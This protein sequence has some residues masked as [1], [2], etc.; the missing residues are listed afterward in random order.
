MEAL[1]KSARRSYHKSLMSSILTMSKDG[2]PSNADKA[3]RLS[4]D[5]ASG[6][7]RRLGPSTVA[8]KVAG[9]T[10]GSEYETIN[11]EF[12][13]KTFLKM[14]HIRPGKWDIIRLGNTKK[15]GISEY[16]QYAHLYDLDLLVKENATLATV[17]GN[18]YTVTPDVII[19]K[20][21]LDDE[22]INKPQVLVDGSA[23]LRSAIRKNVG[24]KPFLHASISSKWT[25]R[26]DRS[27]NSRTEALN[28]IRNRKGHLP[29][30][31]AVTAEPMPS[32][33]SSIALGTGDIDCVYH[34]MLYELV[35]TVDDLKKE[36][37][38]EMLK[39]MIEGRRLKDISDLPLDL[40]L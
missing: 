11:M 30:I 1:L 24:A 14:G 36:D 39:I 6:I 26:S 5:I 10:S 33:I 9:Q 15:S 2:V 23:S 37:S 8:G 7:M 19:V 20:N 34:S 13:K 31:V 35:D 22:E 18:D 32:R 40:T 21:P 17:L 38:Q 3:S 28:L 12:I 4:I 29:H 16:E 27:Q 25:I